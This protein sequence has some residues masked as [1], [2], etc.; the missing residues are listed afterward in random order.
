[1]T[2]IPTKTDA[3]DTPPAKARFTKE[4]I[5]GLIY[6]FAAVGIVVFIGW[7]LY[8]NVS[9]NLE[10]LGMASGFRFLDIAAG[11]DISWS[12]VPYE[13]GDNYGRVYLVGITNT[14][15]V[16]AMAIIASTGLG[17]VIGVSRLSRNWLVSR[18]ASV[19]VEVVRNT[20]A[21][22]QVLFWFLAVFSIL[23]RPKNGI[24]VAGLGLLQINNR[25]I[26]FPKGL[27]QEGFGFTLIALAL[28]IGAAVAIGIWARR[29]R[30]L[31]GQRFPVVPTV[32]AVVILV[33]SLVFLL[34]GS[35][36]G[37]EFPVLQGF[38]LSGGVSFPPALCA[39][40]IAL[41][42]Y[43]AA[44]IGEAV[45]AGILSVS[46]GQAEASFSL[47]L[48]PNW[49]MRMIVVPQ[50]LRAIVPLLIS[51]WM[52]TVKGSSLA[53]A[54]GFPEITALFLQTS[55]NQVGYAIEIVAMVM[56]FYCTVSISISL[57]LNYYNKRVQLKER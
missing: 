38:N 2:T 45:R 9:R 37:W 41:S 33:P 6:Q 18:L 29:R 43:H 11:F 52:N 25:G 4:S 20:P 17:F 14:L 24:D 49:T 7:Y 56:L 57:L 30:I 5:K 1:M 19:Y 15:I 31:T 46:P 28:A 10:N 32:L 53:V 39:V 8:D 44:Y 16:S 40:F 21:L 35:P 3:V 51:Q 13:P 23:P 26:Y 55:L 34:T 12:I 27:P 48:K 50:A 22:I 54:V 36:L 47:G 42:I